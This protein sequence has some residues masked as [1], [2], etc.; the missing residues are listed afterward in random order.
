MAARAIGARNRRKAL[1]TALPMPYNRLRTP[2]YGALFTELL[3]LQETLPFGAVWEEYC[4]QAARTRIRQ[5]WN[6]MNKRF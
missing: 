4:P 1:P 3:M 2:L 6:G 5:K